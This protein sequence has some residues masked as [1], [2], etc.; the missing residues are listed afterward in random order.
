[1]NTETKKNKRIR[2]KIPI[3]TTGYQTCFKSDN[4]TFRT[5]KFWKFG[6]EEGSELSLKSLHSS[7]CHRIS[8]IICS[9]TLKPKQVN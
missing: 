3:I 6:I 5:L 7:K 1:M 9:L 2:S 8:I 4:L